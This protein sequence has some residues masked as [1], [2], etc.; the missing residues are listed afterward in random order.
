MKRT[1]KIKGMTCGH[2][3]KRVENALNQLAGYEV[4]SIKNKKSLFGR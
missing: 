1:V 4:I 3:Q 2:C